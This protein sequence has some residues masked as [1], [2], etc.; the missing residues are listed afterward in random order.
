MASVGGRG[1]YLSTMAVDKGIDGEMYVGST[2]NFSTCSPSSSVLSKS[3]CGICIPYIPSPSPD[4]TSALQNLDT[5]YLHLIAQYAP[6]R[7][8]HWHSHVGQHT[9][10]PASPHVA[11]TKAPIMMSSSKQNTGK[12]KV[13]YERG[14]KEE[15]TRGHRSRDSGVGSSSASD[16]A[17]IGTA[18]HESSFSYQQIEDQRHILG[19]VQEALDAANEKIRALEAQNSHMNLALTESNKENR[20]LKREKGDLLNL[21]DDLRER[22]VDQSK[23]NERMRRE[24]SPRIGSATSA[25]RTERRNTPPRRE[26]VSRQQLHDEER[27]HGHGSRSERRS[28][29]NHPPPSAPPPPPN[30]FA[31]APAPIAHPHPRSSAVTYA[32]PGPVN[33]A[34]SSSSYSSTAVFAVSNQPSRERY[35]DGKYHLS[36]V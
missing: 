27:R 15:K 14:T 6:R 17:S 29:Y 13:H 28:T 3:W 20:L 35:P 24:G 16:R 8:H 26:D 7:H 4:Q 36:P 2:S 9:L 12:K 23:V 18:H 11:H 30:P 5:Q 19:V 32:A 34:P 21:V 25:A 1:S 22:L 31:P 10:A 33:Y